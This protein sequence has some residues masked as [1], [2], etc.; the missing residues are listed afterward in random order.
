MVRP[1]GEKQ[2]V[3]EMLFILKS[4]IFCLVWLEARCTLPFLPQK[5]RY[6]LSCE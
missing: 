4:A 2:T 3:M 6:L 5:A 1:S